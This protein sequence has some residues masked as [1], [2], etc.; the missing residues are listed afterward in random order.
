[1]GDV[2]KP[3]HCSAIAGVYED[4]KYRRLIIKKKKRDVF[5]CSMVINAFVK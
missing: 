4:V 1:M 2:R 3:L 5:L